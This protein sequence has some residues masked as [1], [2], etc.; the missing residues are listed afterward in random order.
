MLAERTS[1]KKSASP[2][3]SQPSSSAASVASVFV[4]S[5]WIKE[6][7][8]SSQS[9]NGP[10]AAIAFRGALLRK[11]TPGAAADSVL[12][13][14]AAANTLCHA[15]GA[16]DF[17]QLEIWEVVLSEAELVPFTKS[18]NSEWLP[19]R[20]GAVRSELIS[21]YFRDESVDRSTAEDMCIDLTF[22]DHQ[23]AQQRIAAA[24]ESDPGLEAATEVIEGI[25][26]EL[27]KRAR[28]PLLLVLTN[29]WQEPAAT[30]SGRMGAA[31]LDG[32]S[33]IGNRAVAS[34]DDRP[35]D[36]RESG[37]APL[38][39]VATDRTRSYLSGF[40]VYHWCGHPCRAVVTCKVFSLLSNLGV[41]AALCHSCMAHGQAR[42]SEPGGLRQRF[43]LRA[44]RGLHIRKCTG[45][46]SL[47]S[48]RRLVPL[49]RASMS[50]SNE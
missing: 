2:T 46:L 19:V 45:L 23:P 22:F 25:V 50:M 5:D 49:P 35:G 20:W 26:H 3:T 43:E 6:S 44:K 36:S 27:E 21:K 33:A 31:E 4:F 9:A 8:S 38:L 37:A 17:C 28:A 7:P 10:A 14:E 47:L 12:P 16:G 29:F 15:R 32:G 24:A 41:T 42:P 34:A 18:T 1:S 40:R 11:E 30:T 13:V 48:Y 39:G